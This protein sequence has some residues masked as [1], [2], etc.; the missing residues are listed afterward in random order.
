[1]NLQLKYFGHVDEGRTGTL[2]GHG[3][4]KWKTR[5]QEGAQMGR[6][7][8][9]DIRKQRKTVG[10]CLRVSLGQNHMACSC[11]TLTLDE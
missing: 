10:M 4:Q 7:C 11:K 6:W 5:K 2:D 8:E 1:M 9:E 3:K